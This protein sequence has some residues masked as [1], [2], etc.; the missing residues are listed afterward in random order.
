MK[1]YHIAAL[2][3]NHVIGKGQDIPW[4]IPSDMK[5]FA[6]ITKGH[7]VVMGSKTFKSLKSKPL[8]GR[9]NVVVGR[10]DCITF[11]G[12][13]HTYDGNLF[14]E[15]RSNTS[16]TIFVRSVEDALSYCGKFPE[17]YIIGGGSIYDQT[18]DLVDELRLTL[19]HQEVEEDDTCVYYPEIDEKEW[20]LSFIDG[21]ETHSYLDYIRRSVL[22]RVS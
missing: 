22:D 9:V 7:P 4:S 6:S 2:S 1:L 17:V 10:A 13:P 21:G 3:E 11:D 14:I 5:R 20:V 16:T 19:V 18:L 12:R 8:P 15:V